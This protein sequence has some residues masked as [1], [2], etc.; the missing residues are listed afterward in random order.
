MPSAR[1]RRRRPGRRTRVRRRRVP[2]LRAD[3]LEAV[4]RRAGRWSAGG[5][6][7]EGRR[8]RD[9]QSSTSASRRVRPATRCGGWCSVDRIAR[10][11][12][13]SPPTGIA[14]E[15][16]PA[17]GPAR[18]ARERSPG[19]SARSQTDPPPD[20][21]TGGSSP[22]VRWSRVRCGPARWA[23]SGAVPAPWSFRRRCL[24]APPRP[25]GGG[26]RP[27]RGRAGPRGARPDAPGPIHSAAMDTQTITPE[28]CLHQLGA[29]AGHRARV[30]GAR[31]AAA[32]GAPMRPRG[33]WASRRSAP[34]SPG[35][36]CGSSTTQPAGPRAAAH[37]RR[38][39]RSTATAPMA[40]ARVHDPGAPGGRPDAARPPGAPPGRRRA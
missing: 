19:P 32:P 13:P 5:P 38:A 14:A 37:R 8:E 34:A 1:S 25:V 9:D 10:P 6:A 35:C 21:R 16:G 7:R 3:P 24:D 29:A 17:P 11:R 23:R 31:G 12:L 22:G 20:H 33:S 30:V 28:P 2:T 18:L 40:I 4:G 15:E 36:W 27:T 26:A 39:G